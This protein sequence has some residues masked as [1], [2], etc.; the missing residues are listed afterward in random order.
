[1]P[2]LVLWAALALGLGG[3]AIEAVSLAVRP[4]VNPTTA[5]G[6]VA[7][8][9]AGE[10]VT[11]QFKQCG[12]YPVQFRDRAEVTTEA[13][14]GWSVDIGAP[15]NGTFRALSGGAASN[16]V[17]VLVRVDVRLAPHGSRKYQVNVVATLPFWKKRVLL[18]R[19]DRSRSA[20]V[21]VRKLVLDNTFGPGLIWS[22][23]DRFTV[24]LPRGTTIRAVLPLDQ[25]KPCF[26]AGYSKL[27]R[28]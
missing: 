4:L 15:T 19:F 18:Q 12:L 22:T 14:G 1:M 6:S 13:G 2:A 25:A 20:W 11:V 9:K 10:K 28:T 8:G 26:L 3:G 16:E 7:S 17:S 5:Y 21:N 27:V 23:T 24:K